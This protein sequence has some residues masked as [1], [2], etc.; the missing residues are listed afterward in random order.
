MITEIIIT[1]STI[2]LVQAIAYNNDILQDLKD[3]WKLPRKPFS[4]VECLGFWI[5]SFVGYFLLDNN[6]HCLYFG[7]TIS[8]L[9][10]MVESYLRRL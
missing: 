5:G 7:A 6:Y 2:W 4:C 10:M 8:L 9:S 1:F 3:K